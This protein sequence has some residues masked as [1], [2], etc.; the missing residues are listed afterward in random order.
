M[1]PVVKACRLNVAGGTI[2][3]LI[4]DDGGASRQSDVAAAV[5]ASRAE[6][7]QAV[8]A[9]LRAAAPSEVEEDAA[10]PA[11]NDEW[12]LVGAA[13]PTA[14]VAAAPAAGAAIR[15]PAHGSGAPPAPPTTAIAV[16]P[17][18]TTDDH[19]ADRANWAERT[20]ATYQ[21]GILV[22]AEGRAGREIQRALALPSG[23][24]NRVWVVTDC[25]P[26]HV[27]LFNKWSAAGEASRTRIGSIV[28]VY[29]TVGEAKAYIRGLGVPAPDR[30]C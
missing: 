17:V 20:E 18:A 14:A 16:A 23:L 7:A 27:G 3:I 1:F 15:E 11:T 8:V 30:P 13:E 26:N 12:A 4:E 10:A 2:R 22:V 24:R 5:G 19:D 21:Y 28:R 9:A 6:I 25:E 29:A